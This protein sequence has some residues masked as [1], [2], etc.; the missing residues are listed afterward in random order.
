[1]ARYDRRMAVDLLNRRIRHAA[2]NPRVGRLALTD[3]DYCLFEAID[4]HGPLP[5]HYLYEFTRHLR[6]DFTHL[7]NRLTEFYNGDAG[8]PYLTRPP[9]QFAGFAARYQHLVYDLARRARIALAERGTRSVHHRRRTDPFLHRLM[10]ACVGASIELGARAKPLR[11]IP[12]A[13]IL[14]HPNAAPACAATN[15]LAISVPGNGT[16]TLIPDDLFG[17]E[18]PGA[19]FRFFAVEVDRNTESIERRDIMQSAFGRKIAGY[20]AVL[21][22]RRYRSWWGIP[23]LS[24]L[25]ITTNHVHAANILESVRRRAAPVAD[26]FAVAVEPSFGSNWRVPQG[27]LVHLIGEPWATVRGGW[28]IGEA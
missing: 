6:R 2:P 8:G 5:T 26:R 13:E 23:N 17:L 18:Y 4:R 15:P 9:Q 1:M 22:T 25:T 19:G 10:Q 24:I 12:L 7:Q 3:A 27:L 16:R 11:Y 20:R 21:E 14:A 28:R